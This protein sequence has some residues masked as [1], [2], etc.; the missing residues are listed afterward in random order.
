MGL[1]PASFTSKPSFKILL[2]ALTG[3]DLIEYLEK[4]NEHSKKQYRD[5]QEK[6]QR[7][8]NAEKAR[9]IHQYAYNFQMVVELNEKVKNMNQDHWTNKAYEQKNHIAIMA[10]KQEN[11]DLSDQVVCKVESI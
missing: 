4:I 7:A 9:F 1:V 3:N 5:L 11:M 10:L 8:K 6:Y 2:N